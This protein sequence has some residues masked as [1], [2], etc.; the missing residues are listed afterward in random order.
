MTV[1][2]LQILGLL[3]LLIVGAL[4][5]AGLTLHFMNKLLLEMFKH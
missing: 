1:I 3:F 4:A 5:V 2:A